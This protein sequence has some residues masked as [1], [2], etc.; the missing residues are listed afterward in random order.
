MG[1]RRCDGVFPDQQAL[2]DSVANACLWRQRSFVECGGYT[3]QRHPSVGASGGWDRQPRP[4]TSLERRDQQLGLV[5]T[6]WT[7]ATAVAS[8]RK[9][10]A[11]DGYI[12]PPTYLGFGKGRFSSAIDVNTTNNNFVVAWG[13]HPGTMTAVFDQAGT[14][15]VNSTLVTGR[16]GFD[17]SLALAF[18][19][20]S[21]TLLAVSSDI[22]SFEIGGVEV[23]G[24]GAPNGLAQIITNGATMGSFYPMV[25]ARGG[26][27]NWGV[28]Y[29]RTS[30]ARRIN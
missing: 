15:I 1:N 16:L 20:V 12:W 25:S 2:S 18:N 29:T 6:G 24:Y 5:A 10:R 28:V 7:P 21:G 14:L 17:Q 3:N 13:I 23:T 22:N 26:L 27:N 19:P 9:I 11:F 8:F 4:G 30:A